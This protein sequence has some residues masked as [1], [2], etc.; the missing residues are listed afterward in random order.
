MTGLTTAGLEVKRLDDI[1]A[2]LE[3]TLKA[4]LGDSL[5]TGPDTVA[6]VLLGV[7]AQEL[8]LVWQ[9]AQQLYDSV[10]PD[11]AEGAA[12]DAISSLVGIR[13]LGQTRS[14]GVVT[15]TGT[16][17]V[18]VPE[19]TIFE[20]TATLDRFRTI[21]D[22]TIEAGGTVD[23][24]VEGIDYGA[25]AA[26]AGTLTEIVTPVSGLDSVSNAEDITPGRLVESDL[27]LRTR[28]EQSLQVTGASV[29]IAIRAALAEL[30]GV[31]AA[32]VVS[33][34]S[35]GVV[36][37]IPPHAFES[38]VYPNPSDEAFNLSVVD[39]IFRLQ[40][41][42]ILAHGDEVYSVTDA[43]GYA[44]E[45]GFSFAT[46]VEL[47]IAATITRGAGYPADGDGQV[48]QALL[49]EGATLSVGDDVKVW[50][51]VAA[52]DPIPGIVDVTVAIDTIPSPVSTSNIPIGNLEISDFDSSRVTVT[53]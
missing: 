38:V 22:A 48:A 52:L 51:F 35:N 39:T 13:R 50:K 18:L 42:G 33:N 29:D 31:Q 19:G 21:V 32:R 46:E 8:S 44:Q 40:P 10:D 2:S 23:V 6:G 43:E 34:R 47:Y 1:V 12:L 41:A 36:D 7:F 49:A 28:R 24:S 26:L 3:D 14:T 17:A 30:D 11:T 45:V 53:S 9:L 25:L 5:E 4:E 15:M 27:E 37:G 16:P 20:A